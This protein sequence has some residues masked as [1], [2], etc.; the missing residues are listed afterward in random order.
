MKKALCVIGIVLSF[1]VSGCGPSQVTE[2]TPTFTQLQSNPSFIVVTKYDVTPS[3]P[4]AK[5]ITDKEL[6]NRIVD[7]M[8]QG[9]S[10]VISDN[11]TLNCP[12]QTYPSTFYD[13]V[14]H[15]DTSPDRTFILTYAGCIFLHDEKDGVTMLSNVPSIVNVMGGPQDWNN[16]GSPSR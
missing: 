13:M 4:I 7:E 15:Y 2:P 10:R 8:N 12:A 6:L 3:P 16:R 11:T 1:L 9:K 14:I 5:K